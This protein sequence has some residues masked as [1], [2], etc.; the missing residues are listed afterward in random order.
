MAKILTCYLSVKEVKNGTDGLGDDVNL[1]KFSNK[2]KKLLEAT[3]RYTKITMYPGICGTFFSHVSNILVLWLSTK[4][5]ISGKF[6]LGSFFAFNYLSVNV[7]NIIISIV[8]SYG[9]FRSLT[10][11][12]KRIDKIFSFEKERKGGIK[13]RSF[14]ESLVF[15]NVS[16][17]YPGNTSLALKD[18]N[19]TINKGEKIG[20][21]GPSGAGKS[22]LAK[23]LCGF[24]T[25]D[26]G[27]IYLDGIPISKIDLSDLR[28]LIA[29]IPQENFLFS[30]TVENN[31]KITNP[32]ATFE[33]VVNSAKYAQAHEFIT[34][35][36]N[37]YNTQC[38]RKGLIFSGGERQ[39]IVLAQLFL[40]NSP[41]VILDES[42]RELDSIKEREILNTLFKNF[43]KKTIIL[44]THR[45]SSL[46]NCDKIVVIKDGEVVMIGT[47][48]ELLK[49]CKL[50]KKLW[51]KQFSKGGLYD[52]V[53]S[54]E[55]DCANL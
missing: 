44:I 31:I 21:V 12:I 17:R 32:S 9:S 48:E 19:L 45:V 35:L 13:V 15:R 53:H 6:S 42:F 5:I 3:M 20:I 41:I 25:P 30:D 7:H 34:R 18:I 8:N 37:G 16:F 33:E 27:E 49:R 23:L 46:I 52:V 14:D 28:K 4:E 29:F 11:S 10:G 1:R 22:T 54:S 26:T 43:S 36:P 40:K 51:N 2:M 47:H 50:Y 39:R 38:G 24:L 55:L